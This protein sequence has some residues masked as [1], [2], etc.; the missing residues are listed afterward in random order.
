[1]T[2]VVAGLGWVATVALSVALASGRRR[3]RLVALAE[4]ELRGPA[5]ALC[6]FLER[7]QRD[8]RTAVHARPLTL[9]LD[10]LRVALD[11]LGAARRGRRA[12]GA[13]GDVRLDRLA[14]LAATGARLA[15]AG[16]DREVRLDW[17]AGAT[18]VR[19]DRRRLSQ[20]LA[21]LTANALEHGG[22]AVEIRGREVGGKVRLE[23]RDEGPRARGNGLAIAARAARD[24]GGRLLLDASPEG[25]TAALELPVADTSEK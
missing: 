5:A 19:A 13:A 10:R 1:V 22:G 20:A 14:T 23:V 4:H 9:E 16:A 6:L 2:L 7:M 25:T 21:N 18:A 8:P 12:A 24:A 11:D 15:A 3:L 17:R